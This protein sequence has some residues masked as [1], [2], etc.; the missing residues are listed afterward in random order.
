MRVPG[1]YVI[2]AEWYLSQQVF[3]PVFRL[4]EHMEGTDAKLLADCLGLDKAKYSG[5]STDHTYDEVNGHLDYIMMSDMNNDD[6]EK[7]KGV[8]VRTIRCKCGS[9]CQLDLAQQLIEWCQSD[10]SSMGDITLFKCNQCNHKFSTVQLTNWA[11][12]TVR[13]LIDRYYSSWMTVPHHIVK[14]GLG[15]NRTRVAA[16]TPKH[17][18]VNG[19]IVSVREEFN[20][21]NL[22]L[23]IQ[24]IM[25]MFDVSRAFKKA[26]KLIEAK[27][28]SAD[29]LQLLKKLKETAEITEAEKDLNSVRKKV[30]QVLEKS[31]RQWIQLGD[32]FTASCKVK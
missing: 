10:S 28:N 21:Q 4:C 26:K 6:D 20:A 1:T 27:P 5:S 31:G 23:H 3:P 14:A 22:Q 7:Y 9:D 32:L 29:P 19:M 12:K 2:D 16:M 25:H 17:G 18:I 24:Y 8:K 30:E 11:Q 13:E 15:Q